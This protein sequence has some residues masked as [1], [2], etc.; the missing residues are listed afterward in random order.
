MEL[1]PIFALVYFLIPKRLCFNSIDL[2]SIQNDLGNYKDIYYGNSIPSDLAWD[3]IVGTSYVTQLKTA[4]RMKKIVSQSNLDGSLIILHFDQVDQ[5]QDILRHSKLVNLVQN[6]WIIVETGDV[7]MEKVFKFA[8][9]QSVAQKMLSIQSQ[10]FWISINNDVIQVL[11]NAHENPT[12]QVKS[13]YK[14]PDK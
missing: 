9:K 12:Y 11:G 4:T 6:T 7:K 5:I 8:R 10:I 14:I 1:K 13:S 3:N 2:E